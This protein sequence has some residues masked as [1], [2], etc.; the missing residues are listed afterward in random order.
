VEAYGPETYGDHIA[1]L[2][3]ERYAQRDP[4]PAALRLAEL[5]GAG[6]VLE[7]GIGTGRVAVPLAALLAPN[8]IALHGI[9]AS[10]AMVARLRERVGDTSIPVVIGDMRAVAA[11]AGAYSLIYVVFNTFFALLDQD[12]QV[13]CF[14][15]V[16]ARLSPGGRFVIEAFVPDL[17][18]F[19]HGQRTSAV[20]LTVDS[21][22]LDVVVHDAV[23]QRVEGQHVLI[24]ESGTK[25][26]PVALRYAFPSE[27][28]LMAR[29]AGLTLESRHHGWANEPFTAESA[30]H[31]SVWTRPAL[32]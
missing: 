22:D 32:R 14:A 13:D 31:V 23:G 3:D 9:D 10:E 4:A 6:P 7:L 25:L 28:D 30:M 27:L 29:L 20:T 19:E 16:A 8:G 15:N 1:D 26:L 24:R 11:P 2:Y 21:V 12:A 17:S 5:A 18:R